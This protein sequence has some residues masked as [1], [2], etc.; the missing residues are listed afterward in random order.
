MNNLSGWKSYLGCATMLLERI[1]VSVSEKRKTILA[2]A[3]MT[4]YE[5]ALVVRPRRKKSPA[6]AGAEQERA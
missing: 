2:V 3:L 5:S 4:A 1:E 6:K